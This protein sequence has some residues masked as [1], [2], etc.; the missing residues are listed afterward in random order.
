MSNERA[1]ASKC[2]GIRHPWLLISY[3]YLWKPRHQLHQQWILMKKTQEEVIALHAWKLINDLEHFVAFEEYIRMF[4]TAIQIY[5]AKL[6]LIA[7]DFSL[8]VAPF[9]KSPHILT[10]TQLGTPVPSMM[11]KSK[12]ILRSKILW[13]CVDMWNWY[14]WK[15]SYPLSILKN[16]VLLG[17]ATK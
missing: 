11:H 6:R 4:L 17:E 10:T 9:V 15:T 7:L 16:E 12:N 13:R 2:P 8:S 1:A 14:F 5:L 3:F